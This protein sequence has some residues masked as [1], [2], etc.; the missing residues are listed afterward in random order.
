MRCS[1]RSLSCSR[2]RS[3][4]L[5]EPETILPGR[6]TRL[7]SA[8]ATADLPEPL[9]PTIPSTCP[10]LTLTSTPF[11][12]LPTPSLVRN[13][14]RKSRT[15]SNADTRLSPRPVGEV[16]HCVSEQREAEDGE[17]QGDPG[18]HGRPPFAGVDVLGTD[19]DHRAPFRGRHPH[20]RA[21][22]RKTRGQENRP[23]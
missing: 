11:S 9:S 5:T 17:G 21:D 19:G 15:S 4:Y 6:A 14:T 18:E 3:L 22:E 1:A 12:A 2:S 13:S 23:A 8:T 10:S 20:A 16:N 7:T